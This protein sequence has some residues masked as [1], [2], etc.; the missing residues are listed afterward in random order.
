MD[1]NDVFRINGSAG[2]GI[3]IRVIGGEGKDSVIDAS[4]VAGSKKLTQV[5]DS[6]KTGFI[7]SDETRLH[8]SNDSAMNSYNYKS[9][10]YDG[11]GPRLVRD[12]FQ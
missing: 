3:L 7:S 12:L 9:F 6:E 4:S 5:Y 8:I 1:D 10:D 11:K 2:K